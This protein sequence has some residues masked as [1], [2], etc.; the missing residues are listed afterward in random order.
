MNDNV[1]VNVNGEAVLSK[2]SRMFN[3]K[4]DSILL[5]L[6]QNARRAG[7]SKI[8]VDFTK[9]DELI[10]EHDGAPFEDFAPLFSLGDS[11]WDE[12]DTKAEDPAGCGF[13]IAT[14]FDSIMVDSRKNENIMYKVQATKKELLSVGSEFDVEQHS[15]TLGDNNVRLTLCGKHG[16]D[17]YSFPNVAKHFPIRM[18]GKGLSYDKKEE[19]YDTMSVIEMLERV[20]KDKFYVNEVRNGVRFRILDGVDSLK[21]ENNVDRFYDFFGSGGYMDKDNVYFNFH[22]H[23]IYQP[24]SKIEVGNV[25]QSLDSLISNVFRN[26]NLPGR[27]AL[28]MTPEGKSGIRMVLPAR[29]S[30]VENEAYHQMCKDAT[31]ILVDFINSQDKHTLSYDVYKYLG[32]PDRIKQEAEIPEDVRDVRPDQYVCAERNF[33]SGIEFAMDYTSSDRI[34]LNWKLSDYEGYSWYDK[35]NIIKDHNIRIFINDEICEESG[36]LPADNMEADEIVLAVTKDEMRENADV[37]DTLPCCF[38]VEWDNCFVGC[39]PPEMG[40]YKT[41]DTEGSNAKDIISEYIIEH[42][43]ASED[44][45]ADH[46]DTQFDEFEQELEAQLYATFVPDYKEEHDIRSFVD[47]GQ[48]LLPADI[49]SIVLRKEDGTEYRIEKPFWRPDV[50]KVEVDKEETKCS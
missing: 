33:N 17:K 32:G 7:A 18:V 15:C 3:N 16:V 26:I 6:A 24:L 28:I 37:I 22:G 27:T 29:H 11:G 1:R 5:E 2:V 36:S 30:I 10:I 50:K 9:E 49:T 13:F 14:L 45:E 41:K 8:L 39:M 19:T 12:D 23:H 42:W 34:V 40:F 48:H 46:P 44:Y 47:K 4:P 31:D 38:Y 43:T 20:P 35:L 21:S 25:R